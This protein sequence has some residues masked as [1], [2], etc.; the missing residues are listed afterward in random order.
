MSQISDQNILL[1]AQLSAAG[2]SQSVTI[3]NGTA[4][5]EQLQSQV[6]N[7]IAENSHQKTKI[8][9]YESENSRLLAELEQLKVSNGEP[10][11]LKAENGELKAKVEAMAKDQED[12]LELL[13][14]QEANLKDYRRRLKDLGQPVAPSDDES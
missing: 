7:L 11:I 14:D 12:L 5:T 3:Q 9:F 8:T 4:H 13:A 2:G 10:D 6:Q 1:R